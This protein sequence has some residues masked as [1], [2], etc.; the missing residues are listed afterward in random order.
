MADPGQIDAIL[1]E[2]AEK[3]RAMA[4]PIVAETKRIVGFWPG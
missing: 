3:A 2:G 4:A 1:K